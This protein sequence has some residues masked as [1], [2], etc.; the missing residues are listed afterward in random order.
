MP[1]SLRAATSAPTTRHAVTSSTVAV[2]KNGPVFHSSQLG[3]A[4]AARDGVA[5][6]A[7]L[8]IEYQADRCDFAR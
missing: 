1:D 4:C 8:K 7:T 5:S 2:R 3:A 6:T